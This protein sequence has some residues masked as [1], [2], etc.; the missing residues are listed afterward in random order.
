M[1]IGLIVPSRDKVCV[2]TCIPSGSTWLY[3]GV[4]TTPY[5]TV[6]HLRP[7]IR[8]TVSQLAIE[9]GMRKYFIRGT[10]VEWNDEVSRRDVSARVGDVGCDANRPNSNPLSLHPYTHNACACAR[11]NTTQHN[12]THSSLD[13]RHLH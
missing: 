1:A 9:D 6:R 3:F 13:T 4:A 2:F 8:P 10:L 11:T 5:R 12:T 7:H